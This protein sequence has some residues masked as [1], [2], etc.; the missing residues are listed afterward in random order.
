MVEELLLPVDTR[1]IWLFVVLS[2]VIIISLIYSAFAGARKLRGPFG[3]LL[4]SS[5]LIDGGI[6]VHTHAF[7]EYGTA[8]FQTYEF[9]I[10]HVLLLIGFIVL[11]VGSKKIQQLSR[12]IG[13]G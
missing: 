7:L 8:A 6:I 4:A 5:I 9:V 1:I 11:A 12:E 13:F 2:L 10:G 3:Y